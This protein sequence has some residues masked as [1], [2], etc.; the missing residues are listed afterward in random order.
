M[1]WHKETINLKTTGKGLYPLTN[2]ISAIIH[3]WAIKEG[4]CYLFI[5]HTSASIAICESYD[6]TARQ[7]LESFLD[8]LVPEAQTWHH[9]MLEGPADSP[10][11]MRSLITPTSL[12]IPIDEGRLHL[13]TWQGIY[14]FEH[15]TEHQNR[16]I[17]LRALCINEFES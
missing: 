4:M 3:R 2:A 8:H 17:L 1:I 13:G 15:R 11:H 10:A 5:P 6:P 7:D 16:R 9:H 12:T 14:L